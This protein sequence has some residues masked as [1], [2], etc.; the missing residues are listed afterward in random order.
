MKIRAAWAFMG[1]VVLTSTA[2]MAAPGAAPVPRD[3]FVSYEVRAGDKL[4]QLVA[5]YLEGAG[6]QQKLVEI[7]R[8]SKPGLLTVG[9]VL[10]FPRDRLRHVPVPAQLSKLSCTQIV[11]VRGEHSRLL[12]QGD[13]VD[14]GA[15]LRVPASCQ[16]VL[17]VE[18]AGRISLPAGAS[19]RLSALR[20]NALEASPEV[21]IELLDGRIDIEAQQRG[22]KD[23]P[24]NV[25]TP[26]SV[27]GV[28]GTAFLVE[29]D[30]SSRIT[31]VEVSQGVVGARGLKEGQEVRVGAGQGVVIS[32]DGR[33]QGVETLPPEPRISA[34][35]WVSGQW[36]AAFET[37]DS[38]STVRVDRSDQANG[39]P[40]ATSA[41]SARD[42]IPLGELSPQAVFISL[43]SQTAGGLQSPRHH[44]AL[45]KTA[46]PAPGSDALPRCHVR[47]DLSGLSQP[48]LSVQRL[49]AGAPT[50]VVDGPVQSRQALLRGL[51]P[52]QYQ[53]FIR[54][55]DSEGRPQKLEGRFELMAAREP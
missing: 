26:T 45:C 52:G 44:A 49:G 28:R 24:F 43:Q 20:R 39:L 42:A 35:E 4:Q 19:V 9:Q 18:G 21:Q 1:P 14:Q 48:H 7:N 23:A 55:L 12:R 10:L 6:A 34:L 13:T 5:R 36:Q 38:V 17:A 8:L 32:A 31:R 51:V 41:V 46:A 47:F 29:F 30:E 22:P 54:A 40:E 53:W 37:S 33:T 16:A 11:E 15:V 3:E 27:A 25:R 50:A 2:L